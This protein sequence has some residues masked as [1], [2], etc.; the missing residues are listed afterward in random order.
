[1]VKRNAIGYVAAL[2]KQLA[3]FVQPVP[4]W[5]FNQL[6]RPVPMYRYRGC[7]LVDNYAFYLHICFCCC[8]GCCG[9]FWNS[10]SL[11]LKLL[12]SGSKAS[13]DFFSAGY[14]F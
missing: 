9:A 12:F 4:A 14:P 11:D 1:M 5:L 6:F 7:L 3:V 2:G 8:A 10:L 13:S